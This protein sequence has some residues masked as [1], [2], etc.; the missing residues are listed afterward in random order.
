MGGGDSAAAVVSMQMLGWAVGNSES[1]V[2][3]PLAEEEEF[4]LS[5]RLCSIMTH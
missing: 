4:A 5:A 1:T 2:L 3:S